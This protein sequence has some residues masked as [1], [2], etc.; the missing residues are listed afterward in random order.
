[1]IRRAAIAILGI[2]LCSAA[3]YADQTGEATD[4]T[5]QTDMPSAVVERPERATL[6]VSV[7]RESGPRPVAL[8]VLYVSYA[9]LQI[10]DASQT[11]RGVA[12]GANETNPLMAGIAGRPAAVWALKAIATVSAIAAAERMWK[13]NRKGAIAVMIVAN[14]LSTAVAAHNVAVLRRQQ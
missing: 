14:G 1:M 6:T 12:H 13:T 11:I 10:V 7:I 3:A 9:A 5:I 8:P 4:A 2:S